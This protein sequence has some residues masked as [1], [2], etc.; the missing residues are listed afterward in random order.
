MGPTADTWLA[1]LEH[2]VCDGGKRI[3]PTFVWL[4]WSAAGGHRHTELTEALCTIAASLEFVQAGALIHDD[5]IDDSATRRGNPSLHEQFAAEHAHAVASSH[6]CGNSRTIGQ[7][8][9]LLL[10]DIAL[11]WAD[12]M[13]FRTVSAFPPLH[14][15]LPYWTSMRTEM[16]TGQYLDMTGETLPSCDADN[17][18]KV[19]R[20][21]TAAYTIERPLHIGAA[22]AN[23]S[24][25]LL[26]GLSDYGVNLGIAFQ[27]R[28]D[29]LGVFGDS[30]KTGKPSGEDLREGKRTQLLADALEHL[31][32]SEHK[33]LWSLIGKPLSE[34]E[35]DRARTLL[36]EC[37]AVTRSEQHIAML[38]DKAR[39]TLTKLLE[40]TEIY[41]PAVTA[42]GEMIEAVTKRDF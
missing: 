25:E 23:A 20:F 34:S 6:A 22:C 35:L 27:L 21:K 13:F 37:G 1:S 33:E 16:L 28:D 18:Q 4:G 5:I 15:A 2:F 42:L 24:P 3:R 9:A 38:A 26:Q 30:T 41:P 17:A 39:H 14:H 8:S 7:S 19:N 12:D 11:T 10:G 36:T 31:R 40:T 29:L 32:P